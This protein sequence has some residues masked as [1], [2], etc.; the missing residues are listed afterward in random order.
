MHPGL[1]TFLA[2]ARQQELLAA[3][4]SPRSRINAEHS[5]QA[6]VADRGVSQSTGSGVSLTAAGRWSVRHPWRAVAVWLVFVIA[7]V[8]VG[9]AVGTKTLSN[10]AVGESARGYAIIDQ[11]RLQLP[12]HELAY[13]HARAAGDVPQ[14]GDAA[15]QLK[16]RFAAHHLPARTAISGD[17]RSAIVVATLDSSSSLAPIGSAIA[18]VQRSHPG[19]RI[20]Q[21]GDISA[22]DAQSRTV[23]VDLHHVELLAI[24]VTLLVL[25]LAFGSLVAAL[26]PVLLGLSAVAAGFGLLGPLSQVFPVQDS[27]KTVILLIGLAVGVDYAL[28]YV[29]RSRQERRRGASIEEALETTMRTSGRTVV[30]SGATVAIAMAGMFI[31]RA[32]V[33]NGIAAG[34]IAVIGCAVAGSLTALPAVL[35]LLG[36]RVERGRFPLRGSVLS[37]RTS[38]FW[39]TVVGAVM[40]RP[41]LAGAASVVLLLALAYPMLS[42]RLAKPSDIA[43]TAQSAPALSAL[44]DVRRTFPS[45]GEPALVVARV[46]PDERAAAARELARLRVLAL[47][48]GVVHPPLGVVTNP[49]HTAIVVTLPLD[50]D[51]ANRPSRTAIEVLRHRLVPE[52]LGR[53][54]GDETA[55]TG[56]SAQDI[57]FTHQIDSALPY[58]IAFVLVLAF[59]LLLAAFRS[60][61]V[62]LKAVVLNLLSVGASY[63]VLA[64]VFEHRWA[65]PILGFRSNGTIV[66]WLPLFLF[67]VL[68]GLS[69][70]YHVFILS[71]VREAVDRGQSTDAAVGHS[72][73]TTAGVVSAAAFVMVCVFAL[74]GTLSSLDLKQA[75]VGLAVAVL[76]DATIIRGVLLPASMTLLGERNWYLPAW[77][78]R[79]P[80]P[81]MDLHAPDGRGSSPL[82][83]G[84]SEQA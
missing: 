21:T 80:H 40:R 10:G 38:R 36:D 25:L 59:G 71:H 15:D 60:L 75:G 69:M 3:A 49:G 50:G 62:P 22:G 17:R 6:D 5:A 33:L 30:I 20:Q 2:R 73:G 55:V 24:P 9:S 46:R 61:V 72:I 35:A 81:A 64:L 77:L 7:S 14:L 8:A 13:I 37:D 52:T 12:A 51:G 44:A 47:R 29:V 53:L 57:D 74:F 48:S 34:T 56:Q 84:A 43:L 79:L 27:A 41:L 45:A 23:G 16:R 67:V 63:G 42:L 54:P 82:A 4:A 83:A 31:A 68:F 1:T 58:V 65:Q 76:L 19:L 39:P 11:E 18:A 32:S 66:A 28:F 70:D 78:Q 26:L